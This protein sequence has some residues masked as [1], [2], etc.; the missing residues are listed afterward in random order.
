MLTRTCSDQITKCVAKHLR[1]V[2]DDKLEP[3]QSKSTL[4]YIAGACG[5]I[6]AIEIDDTSEEIYALDQLAM[7]VMTDVYTV[8][9]KYARDTQSCVLLAKYK[10]GKCGHNNLVHLYRPI[11]IG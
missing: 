4:R 10:S 5:G 8:L 2:A 6:L 1:D 11:M 9:K 3:N 7:I